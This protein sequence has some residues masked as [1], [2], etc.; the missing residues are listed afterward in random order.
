MNR[1]VK[2]TEAVRLSYAILLA[3]VFA[4]LAAPAACAWGCKGHQIVALIAEKHL[5]PQAQAM[6]MQILAA[7]PISSDLRRYC[8]DSGLDAF[9]DSSTWADDERS[10]RPDTAG[11]HFIDIPRGAPKGNITQFC[12]ANEGCV[13]SAITEQLSVLRNGTAP[14]QVRADALRYVVHFVADLHQPLHTNTNDDRG[15]NCV[16]VAFFGREPEETNPVKEDFR[17]NLHSVWDTDIIEHYA[18]GRTAQQIADELDS[19]FKSQI[20]AWQSQSI[21]VSTWAWEA[22]EMAENVVY[23]DLPNKIA[24]EK[25]RE[26]NTCADDDHISTRMLS[27]NERLC[28]D[29]ESAAESAVQQQLAKAGARLAAVLNLVWP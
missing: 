21:D 15:G 14:A 1:Q 7:S 25:P 18:H 17:P 22:H 4:A 10:I 23:G 19:K 12:P 28:S 27:L 9:A 29:Y 5:N 20:S 26:V 2:I 13:T 8:G 24:I 16:P 3:S 6:A 11:W